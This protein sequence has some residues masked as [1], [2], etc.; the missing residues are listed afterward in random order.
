[1]V[2]SYFKQNY[3]ILKVAT[4]MFETAKSLYKHDTI[5]VE[6]DLMSVK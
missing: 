6:T 5:S 2:Y 3:F 4:V 1:M